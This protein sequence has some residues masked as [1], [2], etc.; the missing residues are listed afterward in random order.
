MTVDGDGEILR[1]PWHQWPFEIAT[2]RCLVDPKARVK[3]YPVRVVGNDIVV[4][5]DE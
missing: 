1:C 3:T 2:G 4:E 5:Y